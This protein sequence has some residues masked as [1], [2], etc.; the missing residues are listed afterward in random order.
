MRKSILHRTTL[1]VVGVLVVVAVALG[2][3]RNTVLPHPN[4]ASQAGTQG[5]LLF[6]DKGCVLCH[7]TESTKAKMGP[8]LMGLFDREKLPAS[9][10]P[11]T[12]ENVREQLKDP[13]E[14]MP[15]FA[16]RLTDKERDQIISYLK[17][18]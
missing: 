15:S 10:R 18:L 6:K 7:A 3:L 11:A 16:D 9:G 12:E 4:R 14:N 17:S 13:Y 8:G 1:M 5:A 2:I